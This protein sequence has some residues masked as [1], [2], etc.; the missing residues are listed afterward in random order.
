MLQ[1]SVSDPDPH[2]FAFSWLTIRIRIPNE[3]LDPDSG[4]LKELK[5]RRKKLS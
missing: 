3:D 4:G 1:T 5:L 2:G